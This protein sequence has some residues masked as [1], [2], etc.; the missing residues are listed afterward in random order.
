MKTKYS[1]IIPVYNGEKTISRCLDS[2]LKQEMTGYEIIVVNDGSTD[3]T[4]EICQSYEKKYKQIKY[5]EKENG[6]VSTARNL[7][8]E[9]ACGNYILFVDSDDFVTEDYFVT[10]VKYTQNAC[11]FLMFSKL[12]YDGET[13]KKQLLR[14]HTLLAQK[15][16]FEL[17]VT[18]LKNQLLNSPTNKIYRRDI[19]EKHNIRFD[20]TLVIGEDK[21]FVIQYILNISNIRII[22]EPIYVTS[23]ENGDSLSRKKRY[24]LYK[25]ILKEHDLLFEAIEKS[26][27]P[28]EI[29]KS[30]DAAICYSFYR[31]AYTVIREMQKFDYSK[32]ERLN[33]TKQIC[34]EYCK[35][36]K[37]NFDSIVS[38]VIAF[39]IR[40]KL[41]R[42]I[43]FLLSNRV[44]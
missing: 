27:L 43:D 23:V 33:R 35:R 12:V 34:M 17:L 26:E 29:K 31:S 8:L 4:S 1:V 6:G 3:K 22:E 13:Y 15:E 20:P 14:P 42:I 21:V 11:D 44:K 24:D 18:A 36:E 9:Y 38:R 2:L 7:G 19:I 32:A 30:L 37:T 10:I 25:Q 41:V 5:L 28:F 39:P 40:W 16:T